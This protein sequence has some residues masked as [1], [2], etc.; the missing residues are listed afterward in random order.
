VD[1]QT[2]PLLRA[3]HAFQAVAVPAGRHELVLRYRDRAFQLGA[4]LSLGT[5]A[6]LAL[7]RRALARPASR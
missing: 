1:G 5:L 6:G 7:A 4:V 3:N 2:V